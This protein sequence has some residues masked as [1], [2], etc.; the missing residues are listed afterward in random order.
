M[1]CIFSDCVEISLA[2][3]T[4]F[5]VCAWLHCW[6]KSFTISLHFGRNRNANISSKVNFICCE[7]SWNHR[8]RRQILNVVF[9]PTKQKTKKQKFISWRQSFWFWFLVIQRIK[10][11]NK[12]EYHNN[13]EIYFHFSN[14]FVVICQLA[15]EWNQWCVT[16]A[17][18]FFFLS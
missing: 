15:I 5:F 10:T 3:A 9:R 12:K 18:Y 13:N 6:L 14:L 8:V 1:Q 4:V 7:W 16:G 17:S 2:I 11:N